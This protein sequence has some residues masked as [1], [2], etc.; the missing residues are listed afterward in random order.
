MSRGP[1]FTI[2]AECIGNLSLCH[3][4][5]SELLV[6]PGLPEFPRGIFDA[7]SAYDMHIRQNRLLLN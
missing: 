5:E 2:R 4:S 1:L 6:F 3:N 7:F